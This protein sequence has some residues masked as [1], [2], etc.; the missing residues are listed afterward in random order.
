MSD[1]SKFVSDRTVDLDAVGTSRNMLYYATE[2]VKVQEVQVDTIVG[3][4]RQSL[5]SAQ[6][7]SSSEVTIPNDDTISSVYVY[8]KIDGLPVGISLPEF[9]GHACLRSV[10]YTWGSSSIS[11]IELSSEAIFMHNMLS[12]ETSEKRKKYAELA[13]SPRAKTLITDGVTS[14]ECVLLIPLPWSTIRADQN[15]KG[16]DSSL[17]NNNI[18]IQINFNEA[19]SFIGTHTAGLVLPST[20]SKTLVTLR[21]SVLTNKRDSMKSV[22]QSNPNLMVPYPFTHKSTGTRRFITDQVANEPTN[23]VLQSFLESDL[24]GLA[25]YVVPTS[26]EKSSHGASSPVN[27]YDTARLRDIRLAYNGQELFNLEGHMSDMLLCNIDIG[28]PDC[29]KTTVD[30]AGALSPT[31]GTI[32]SS[33]YHIYYLPFTQMK[34]VIFSQE[35][36]NVSRYAS[37]T[38]ELT[39]TVEGLTAPTNLS[40]HSLYYYNAIA[41]TQQ[42]VTSL[43]FA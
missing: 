8:L 31:S 42:G 39:F 9:F 22:L 37:Q 35:Y 1:T 25:F 13:G 4:Y 24:L 27:K 29:P 6:F 18:L 5:S 23:I 30:S 21:Q 36:N 40:F 33:A 11:T 32:S 41:Q 26:E 15:K 16:Y 2:D 38:L 10:N 12:M 43:Q 3:K 20:F 34:S 19:S 14:A 17:L 28:S 7:G